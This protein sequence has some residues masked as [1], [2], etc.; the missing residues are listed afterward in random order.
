LVGYYILE[1][2]KKRFEEIISESLPPELLNLIKRE[3][4]TSF[5]AVKCGERV[6]NV[7]ISNYWIREQKAIICKTGGWLYGIGG[8]VNRENNDEWIGLTN[9]NTY[10]FRNAG[11][12]KLVMEKEKTWELKIYGGYKEEEIEKVGINISKELYLKHTHSESTKDSA[13]GISI[14]S[15]RKCPLILYKSLFA[16][17]L[18]NNSYHYGINGKHSCDNCS[19]RGHLKKFCEFEDIETLR[20]DTE[21]NGGKLDEIKG[22]VDDVKGLGIAMVNGHLYD[23]I[24]QSNTKKENRRDDKEGIESAKREYNKWKRIGGRRE[25]IK[26]K[27]YRVKKEQ[28]RSKETLNNENANEEVI[29]LETNT[30]VNLIDKGDDKLSTDTTDVESLIGNELEEN[31]NLSEMNEGLEGTNELGKDKGEEIN[32]KFM[33]SPKSK[34]KYH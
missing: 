19:L 28:N 9:G 6:D 10:I 3:K 11:R 16:W 5:T 4:R 32:I 33:G 29:N 13:L 22:F 25:M 31:F 20:K 26:R 1:I 30:L 17:I 7:V 23:K 12:K 24:F 15:F 21:N 18:E 27:K 2:R 34:K 14:I 8:N